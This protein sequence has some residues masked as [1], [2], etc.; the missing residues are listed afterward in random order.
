MSHR[1]YPKPKH[2]VSPRQPP[3]PIPSGGQHTQAQPAHVP[4]RPAHRRVRDP[5]R[6]QLDGAR[7]DD[8]HAHAERRRVQQELV[9]DHVRDHDD[10]EEHGEHGADEPRAPRAAAV[11]E[12]AVDERRRQEVHGQL[13][14][15]RHVSLGAAGRGQGRRTHLRVVFQG[16]VV[17]GG[18]EAHA[19]EAA[20]GHEAGA[21]HF[22]CCEEAIGAVDDCVGFA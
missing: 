9:H 17:A 6:D 8:V 7:G 12:E 13:V 14:R 11:R 3:S 16:H 22:G 19:H 18:A 21:R 20:V 2:T 1:T 4:Q 5:E 10:G 15:W